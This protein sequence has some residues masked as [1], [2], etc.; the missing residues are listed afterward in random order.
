MLFTIFGHSCNF[1]GRRLTALSSTTDA[2]D[3]QNTVRPRR[4][5]TRR[6][7]NPSHASRTVSR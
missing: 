3:M 7:A 4:T 2:G 6:S 1:R 5:W